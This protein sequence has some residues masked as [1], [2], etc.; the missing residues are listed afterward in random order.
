MLFKKILIANRGEIAVRVIRACRELGI[1]SAAIYSDADKTSLHTRLA[2]ESYYI[3]SSPAKESYLNKEKIIKL[4]KEI[5]ADAIHPGYGF[6][7]ENAD[8]IKTVEK[9]N[10]TFIGPSSKSVALMGNKTEARKLMTK[11][12]VPIVPGTTEPIKTI[13]DGLKISEDIGYP[14][15]LKAAAGGGGKGM[16]KITTSSEFESAFEATKREA[17][18]SFANDDIYIEKYIESP[19]HIEVQIFGDKQGNYVHLFER[20]CSIQR[21]HQ[22]IIEEA[23]SSFVDDVTRQKITSAAIDAA[24]ACNYFNAGTVEF[25][26][27]SE[28]NFYFL[29][30]NTRLQVEHPVTELITGLDL[31]K[32]QISVALGNNLSFKQNELK[33]NGHALEC[34]IYAEDPLNNFLPSTG[35]IVHYV[36]P[37]GPGVRVDSGFDNGSQITVHYDPLISKLVC[38]ADNRNSAIERML[39]ALS[40][41]VIG[42]LIS[43]ISFLKLIIDHPSFR[44]GEFDINFLNS[45]FMSSLQKLIK[46]KNI[47]EIER[48]SAIFA[49]ILKSKSSSNNLQGKQKDS[50]SKWQEQMYE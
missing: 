21:R 40:E 6:F 29:E 10:I 2:D 11:N 48:V 25:L 38:W 50:I 30:M 18:K 19:R 16:R 46:T 8:F 17:L 34:R 27:D 33:I 9:N 5:E 47:K 41:Y 15:L 35:Q 4:A 37:S 20:E 44:K 32:E 39:R 24:R 43:N 28:R 26:M 23:P 7:S 45:E 49:A 13:K 42:G 12:K 1:K 36:S 31:V 14:I 3:G 22:K